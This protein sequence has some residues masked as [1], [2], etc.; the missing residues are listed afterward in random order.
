MSARLRAAGA[1][2]LVLL[3]APAL[4]KKRPLAPGERIDLNHAGVAELMR[5]P[6][7]GRHR[8]EAIAARRARQPFRSPAEVTQVKGI[9]RAWF[10]KNRDR[11]SAGPP[12]VAPPAAAAAPRPAR[13]P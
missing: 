13:A 5:L 4:A 9:G 1:A 8:A 3:A 11:L 12:A 2:M 6:G 10:E 7:I